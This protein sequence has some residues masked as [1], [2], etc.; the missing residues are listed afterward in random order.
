MRNGWIVIAFVAGALLVTTNDPRA[1]AAMI[2]AV[3]RST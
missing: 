2:D 1:A 3:T